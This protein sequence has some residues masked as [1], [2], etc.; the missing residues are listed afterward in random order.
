M[1]MMRYMQNRFT[2][3]VWIFTILLP[4]AAR[5]PSF[6]ILL[7]IYTLLLQFFCGVPN[8]AECHQDYKELFSPLKNGALARAPMVSTVALCWDVPF[9]EVCARCALAACGA[10]TFM[11]PTWFPSIVSHPTLNRIIVAI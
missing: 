1:R 9:L 3:I 11:F 4:I 5:C 6:T 7:R 2:N 10:I 8:C